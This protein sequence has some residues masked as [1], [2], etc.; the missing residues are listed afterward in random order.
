M[1]IL[2]L[3]FDNFLA[4]RSTE[5]FAEK[6]L[7]FTKSIV[8]NVILQKFWGKNI[9]RCWSINFRVESDKVRFVFDGLNCF[10]IIHLVGLSH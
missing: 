10:G 5:D 1:R 3:Y 4:H 7:C 8:L 6:L 9:D 2:L